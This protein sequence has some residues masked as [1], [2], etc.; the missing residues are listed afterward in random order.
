[1]RLYYRDI[2]ERI[3]EPPSWFDEYAVPRWGKFEPDSAANIYAREVVLL[4]IACQNCRRRF[5]VC[6]SAGAHDAVFGP[7]R[8]SA[9]TLAE[10]V[11]SRDIGYGDPP[12]IDCCPS[13]PTMSSDAKRVLQFW[14]KE[15]GDWERVPE[16]EIDLEP[17]DSEES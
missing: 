2:L 6:M 1:M 9:R 4:G 12:N 13:G 16:L 14:R 8:G 5:K 11:H 3:P 7:F 15:S 17:W 10:R